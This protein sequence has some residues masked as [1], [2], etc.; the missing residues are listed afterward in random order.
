M[1]QEIHDLLFQHLI[2]EKQPAALPGQ[3]KEN[4]R[5]K[6]AKVLGSYPSNPIVS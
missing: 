3:K 1:R 5:K 6:T 2:F 4:Q